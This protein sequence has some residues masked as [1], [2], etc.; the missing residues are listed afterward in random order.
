MEARGRCAHA[1]SAAAPSAGVRLPST[2]PVWVG[3]CGFICKG[4]LKWGLVQ[5]WLF[6][7]SAIGDFYWTA[8]AILLLL[9]CFL[10]LLP[11]ACCTLPMLAFKP[12]T[13]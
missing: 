1:S 8:L 5:R 7:D 9:A 12:L 10:Q 3:V 6:S 11:A 2:G 4:L 13:C